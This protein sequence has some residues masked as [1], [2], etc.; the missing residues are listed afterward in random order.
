MV[1]NLK[2]P[3]M[4]QVNFL[5][6]FEVWLK[7]PFDLDL[8]PPWWPLDQRL[9]MDQIWSTW[10]QGLTSY[11]RDLEWPRMTS[12]Q[13]LNIFE[14]WPQMTF[15]LEW[16]WPHPQKFRCA[17]RT[18]TP[19]FHQVSTRRLT[20][21]EI[22]FGR[23]TAHGARRTA[24]RQSECYVSAWTFQARQKRVTR[25]LT[26]TLKVIS[27]ITRFR[28]QNVCYIFSHNTCEILRPKYVSFLRY[29]CLSYH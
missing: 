7:W 26:R 10:G 25:R 3:R 18:R 22:C 2:W 12:G 17:P 24:H 16:P 23:R 14:I 6:I 5:N 4:T 29:E 11:G 28:Y 20:V 19:S 1:V 8:T 9:S 13:L 27:P 15:W 21:L